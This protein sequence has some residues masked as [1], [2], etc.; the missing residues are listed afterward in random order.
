MVIVTGAD[1]KGE[2][3]KI[4]RVEHVGSMTRKERA[5][6]GSRLECAANDNDDSV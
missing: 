6:R 3:W 1:V 5:K 2:R 4:E